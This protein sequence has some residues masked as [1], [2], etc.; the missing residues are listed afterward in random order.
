MKSQTAAVDCQA[1]T[2]LRRLSGSANSK[3]SRHDEPGHWQRATSQHLTPTK[4]RTAGFKQADLYE[5]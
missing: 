3:E 2:R 5:L 4:T 1:R